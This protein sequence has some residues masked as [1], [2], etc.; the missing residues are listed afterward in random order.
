[1]DKILA[2]IEQQLNTS[3]TTIY[4]EIARKLYDTIISTLAPIYSEYCTK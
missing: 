2:D 1:M 3:Q 4:N